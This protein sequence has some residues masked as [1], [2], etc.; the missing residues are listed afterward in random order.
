MTVKAVGAV[1]GWG[2][3]GG[4]LGRG[5]W[6]SGGS[7]A[8]AEVRS[9]RWTLP[10]E[11]GGGNCVDWAGWVTG[12]H[13]RIADVIPPSATFSIQTQQMLMENTG[14]R[15]MGGVHASNLLKSESDEGFLHPEAR[16]L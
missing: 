9:C 16:T 15:G 11:T 6:S 2:W 4:G 12:Q 8:V 1:A 14:R 3:R 10:V 13:V 5:R 7:A